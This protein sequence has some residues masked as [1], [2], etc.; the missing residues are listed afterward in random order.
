MHYINPPALRDAMWLARL[1]Q[2]QTADKANLKLSTFKSYLNL[3]RQVPLSAVASLAEAL[4]CDAYKLVGPVDPVN[5]AQ[6]LVKAM[7]VTPADYSE[8]YGAEAAA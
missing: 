5:T 1:T 3:K 2:E 8:F 4:N 7:G 6:G